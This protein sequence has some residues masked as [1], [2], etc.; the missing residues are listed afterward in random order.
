MPKKYLITLIEREER[1]R[2]RE[3][4]KVAAAIRAIP[5][6]QLA[7]LV[8][9][10]DGHTITPRE[11]LVEAGWPEGAVGPV[12]RHFTDSADPSGKGRIYGPGGV[13]LR[14]MDGVYLLDFA[15]LV[16]SA[17][18]ADTARAGQMFGRGRACAAL[19]RAIRTKL[20]G[21]E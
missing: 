12:R 19:V 13:E 18:G 2:H 3:R 6:A 15:W 16:A 7:E 8:L 4:E 21:G 14:Q 11:K 20:L 9:M 1:R 17:V 10:L 5:P